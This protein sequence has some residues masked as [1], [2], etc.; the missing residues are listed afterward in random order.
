MKVLNFVRPE[1][2][3]TEDPLYYMNFEKYEDVA[4]AFTVFEKQKSCG[5]SP[6]N[7]NN[8]SGGLYYSLAPVAK[9]LP[10]PGSSAATNWR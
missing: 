2:G 3:L 5:K 10:P 1:N 4:E 6:D 9:T 7:Q 8:S